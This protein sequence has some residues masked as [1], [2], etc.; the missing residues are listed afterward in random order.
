MDLRPPIRICYPVFLATL[1]ALGLAAEVAMGADAGSAAPSVAEEAPPAKKAEAGKARY[2]NL[3]ANIAAERARLRALPGRTG[4]LK[5]ESRYSV[6]DEEVIIRDFFQDRR[7][8][9]FVDVGCAWPIQ[10]NNTYY[11]EHHL[12]WT[13]VGIDALDDYAPQWQ[14]KRPGAKFLNY[15]VTDESSGTGE[16]YRSQNLGLSSASKERADGRHF[17]GT[18]EVEKIEVPAATLNEILD[19]AG[20]AR[21]DLLS[22]DIEGH[23]IAAL[24]GLDLQRF[25]P[26]L[27]VSEG[28]RPEVEALLARN[29]YERIERYVPFDRTNRYYR[30]RAAGPSSA[31][32]APAADERQDA[33]R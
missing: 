12:G 1:L 20:I 11:L 2:F 6:F 27:I 9:V 4:L 31:E 25:Q 23:E 29:G 28:I 15:L 26:E 22:L 8:G 14:E 30:R 10:A 21:I 3:Q 33:G 24:R 18:L 13:G 19:A 16:F 32:T 17:G 5:E 7:D